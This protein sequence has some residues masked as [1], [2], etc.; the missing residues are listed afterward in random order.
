VKSGAFSSGFSHYILHGRHE[1][2]LRPSPPTAEK[3]G[4]SK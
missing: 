3:I 2:R 4:A 1:G